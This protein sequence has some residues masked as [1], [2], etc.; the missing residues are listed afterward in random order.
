MLGSQPP[1]PNEQQV[2][3][4]FAQGENESEE[5][6]LVPTTYYDEPAS[7]GTHQVYPMYEDPDVSEYWHAAGASGISVGTE[8]KVSLDIPTLMFI[9][10]QGATAKPTPAYPPRP[11]AAAP[12]QPMGPCYKCGG[13]H[14]IRDCPRNDIVRVNCFCSDCGT[15]H[16]I[17]DCPNNP[18]LKP[19]PTINVLS[20]IPSS[21]SEEEPKV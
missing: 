14:R 11:Y 8:G 19:N 21:G 9:A 7:Q 1:L 17:V 10:G 3:I 12:P 15:T 16:M 4:R 5:K 6:G 18:N 13:D 20:T 2:A